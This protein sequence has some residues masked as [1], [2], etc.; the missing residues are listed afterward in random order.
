[1]N[2]E[3]K[4]WQEEYRKGNLDDMDMPGEIRCI[5]DGT[6]ER[7]NRTTIRWVLWALIPM[8][9]LGIFAYLQT[10]KPMLYTQLQE[11][12]SSYGMALG[13]GYDPTSSLLVE[14]VIAIVLFNVVWKAYKKAKIRLCST[15]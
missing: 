5:L 8:T 4:Y 2:S 13:T 3:T 9:V 6:A 11:I 7:M 15:T 1:M 12:L 10:N 14:I